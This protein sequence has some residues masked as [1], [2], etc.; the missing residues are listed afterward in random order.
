MRAQSNFINGLINK[1]TA[2]WRWCHVGGNGSFR[3]QL[4]KKI[5]SL[6]AVKWVLLVYHVS[7]HGC[8]L[9]SDPKQREL[10]NCRSKQWAKLNG[11]S[12]TLTCS[13]F[14]SQK[15]WPNTVSSRYQLLAHPS[16]SLPWSFQKILILGAGRGV[17]CKALGSRPSTVKMNINGT[18]FLFIVHKS[19]AF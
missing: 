1:F 9:T 10:V 16:T 14:V 18:W 13:R 11:S 4:W 6:S 8:F 7:W 3:A 15:K 2:E 12:L 19:L 5:S 17:Q